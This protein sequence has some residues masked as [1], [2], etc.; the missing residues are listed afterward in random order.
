MEPLTLRTGMLAYFDSL[1]GLVPC[2]VLS[3]SGFPGRASTAQTVEIKITADCPGWKRGEHWTTN[4]LHAVPRRAIRRGKIHA[5]ILPYSVEVDADKQTA[6]PL[7]S[8][9]Y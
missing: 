3:V 1:R 6:A 4:G 5:R 8:L 7:F 2:R 9:S